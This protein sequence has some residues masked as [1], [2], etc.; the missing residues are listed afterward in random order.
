MCG[1]PQSSLPVVQSMMLDSIALLPL[2]AYLIRGL[3]G[4]LRVVS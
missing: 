2:T 3:G 1:K 4:G